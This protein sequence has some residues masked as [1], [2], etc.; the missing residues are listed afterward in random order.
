M[1]LKRRLLEVKMPLKV[2]FFRCYYNLIRAASLSNIGVIRH[3][4]IILLMTTLIDNMDGMMKNPIIHDFVTL[5]LL[6]NCI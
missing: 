4:L 1:L 6:R 5:L 3:R 2:V